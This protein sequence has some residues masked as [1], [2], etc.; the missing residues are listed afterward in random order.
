MPAP[1]GNRN[2]DVRPARMVR[3]QPNRNHRNASR[4]GR[5]FVRPRTQGIYIR[6]C[7]S[8][9]VCLLLHLQSQF[10]ERKGHHANL[11]I[12]LQLLQRCRRCGYALEWHGEIIVAL[13]HRCEGT[14]ADKTDCRTLVPLRKMRHS[15]RFGALTSGAES[16]RRRINR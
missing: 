14:W 13:H 1:F 3:R 16:E 6:S 9:L 5:R 12:D 7:I 4:E 8:S 11:R 2:F 15:N 10:R